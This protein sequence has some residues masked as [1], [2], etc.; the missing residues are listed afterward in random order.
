MI[1]PQRYATSSL[2]EI[3]LRYRCRAHRRQPDQL[4]DGGHGVGGEL[5]A[6]R[7]RA[8]TRVVLDLE[9]LLVGDLA[10]GSR[11]YGFENI[12]DGDVVALVAARA[13]SSRH[14]GPRRE[15]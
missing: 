15:Y 14:K 12:L 13:E 7:A 11:A 1:S 9:Q 10:R 8:G 4:H 6:A 5:A 3:H 2:R